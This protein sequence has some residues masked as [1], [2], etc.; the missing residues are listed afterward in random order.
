MNNLKIRLQKPFNPRQLKNNNT[1][2]METP[3]RYFVD[4]DKLIPK[5]ICK[6]KGTKSANKFN[7]E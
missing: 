5:F 7:K 6:G 4:R 2:S 3:A 1:I